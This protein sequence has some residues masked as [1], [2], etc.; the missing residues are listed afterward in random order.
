MQTP[1]A[2]WRAGQFDCQQPK[3]APFWIITFTL[4]TYVTLWCVFLS[5][6]FK[7]KVFTNAHKEDVEKVLKGTAWLQSH[8][9]V[10]VKSRR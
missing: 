8:V 3:N 1:V 5:I 9:F 2:A 7:V 4:Q 10:L 6:Y